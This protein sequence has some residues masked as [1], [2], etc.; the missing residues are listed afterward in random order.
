MLPNPDFLDFPQM[1]AQV[2]ENNIKSKPAILG[3]IV[4]FPPHHKI[5]PE[6]TYYQCNGEAK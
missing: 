6:Q 2:E 4:T 3:N 1:A 5:R